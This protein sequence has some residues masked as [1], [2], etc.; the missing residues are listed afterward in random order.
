LGRNVEIGERDGRLFAVL[1]VTREDGSTSN[2]APIPV[3]RQFALTQMATAAA[4]QEKLLAAAAAQG[5][6]YTLWKGVL[7]QVEAREQLS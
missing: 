1:T 5:E 7:A 2:S 6:E 4:E 3:S